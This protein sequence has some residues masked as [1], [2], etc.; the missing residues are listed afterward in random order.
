MKKLIAPLL[1]TS[2]LL[3]GCSS[4]T[5]GP[6]ATRATA[7]EGRRHGYNGRYDGPPPE[8]KRDVWERRP[9]GFSLCDKYRNDSARHV[10]ACG[11]GIDEAVNM[12]SRFAAA[13]GREDGYMR[14]YAWGLSQALRAFE[15]H[16]E[17][18]RRGENNVDS[19][20]TYMNQARSE[21][22]NAGTRDG[23]SLGAT[24]AKG[25]YYRAI[26][27][28]VM[29]SPTVQTPNFN[30]TPTQDAYTQF[31]GRIPT[32]EEILKRD[33]YGRMGFYDTYDRNYGGGKDWRERNHRDLWSREGAYAPNHK[34][35]TNGEIAIQ[36]W[37]E[38]PGPGK[39]RYGSLNEAGGPNPG[40]PGAPVTPPAAPT[41]PPT[42][43]VAP[44]DFQAIF[45]DAFIQAYNAYAP[46]DYSRNYH[47]T[48]D[49]GQ[50]DGEVI[51]YE[52][53]S[54]I[55]QKKGLARA[56]NRNYAQTSFNSYQTSFVTTYSTSFNNTFNFYK[57]NAVL[58]LNFLGIIGTEDDGV[59]QPGESFGVKF[60]VTNAGGVPS[61]LTY[62]IAGDVENVQALSDSVNAISTKT[63]TSATIGEVL[64][65]L[66]D[67]AN[68]SYVLD[69]NGIKEK[70]WQAIKRPLEMSEIK[71]NLSPLDGSGMYNITLSNISTVPMNGTIALELRINGTVVKSAVENSMQP[72]DKKLFALDFSK[73][74]PLVWINSSYN[75]EILLK[76]NGNIFARK[77]SSLSV[78]NS[79]DY[80]AQ[81]F[82]RLINEK[83]IFP[84]GKTLDARLTEVKTILLTNNNSEVQR[85]IDGSGNVYRTNPEST[86]PGI[87]LKAKDTYG[88]NS[89]R[90]IGEFTGLADSMAPLAKKFK[91]T[92]FIH[93]K[94]DAYNELMSKIGGKKYK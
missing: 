22:Q 76:Y 34:N 77:T 31:V 14:G 18:L 69:V 78:S 38:I 7:S 65:S 94:R 53:G 52:V 1:I 37:M 36:R 83:G 93:P 84:E 5:P 88:S 25:R 21:G 49:D 20:N 51:G 73:L 19:L 17:E 56:F 15:D 44:V 16:P 40:R 86:V 62:T 89:S 13:H 4:I 10:L 11:A 59:V 24:E 70:Q 26:D 30:F 74:D 35:W 42:P 55:A 43:P 72:G 66:E 61:K 23:D 28:K 12:S 8:F 68:G 47:S 87:I 75:V 6:E 82:T 2:S 80:L 85:N 45:R 57:N 54:E 29:P 48:I 81:Y 64:A 9:S 92:L 91:S 46:G 79:T 3:S 60:K 50:R 41:T 63:I 33:R 27:T 90:A 58:S 71:S 39:L 32:A 67:G